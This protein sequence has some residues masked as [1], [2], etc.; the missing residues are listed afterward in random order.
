M[1]EKCATS[2]Y[3]FP[4]IGFL[5]LAQV[6]SFI[7][8]SKTAWYEGIKNGIYPQPIKLSERSKAYRTEDIRELITQLSSET[9]AFDSANE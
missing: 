2:T 7:P 1:N 6:L 4:E 8:V 5:R 9:I 3:K